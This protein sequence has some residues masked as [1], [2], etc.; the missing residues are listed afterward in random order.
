MSAA[1]AF[2]ISKTRISDQVYGYLRGEILSGRLAPGDR[3]NL[4]ALVERLKISKMPVK[5][6]IGRL[7]AEGLLE[8]LPQ[9]GTFVS[10]VD[11]R[12]LAET[13]A[14]RI[15]LEVL[16]GKLAVA[17]VSKAELTRLRE[18]IAEMETSSSK[19]EAML[20]ID[21]NFAF[22]E[23]IINLSD[24]RRLIEFY[25]QLRTPIQMAGVHFGA[26]DWYERV[27]QDQKEHRHIVRALEQ[28]NAAA[29]EKAITAHLERAQIAM[30]AHVER[31]TLSGAVPRAQASSNGIHKS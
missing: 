8:V 19:R 16:A 17:Q 21:K 6:A 20:Y 4:E 15:A 13:Y 25:R 29:V 7:A 26:E 10:R 30:V 24:N 2:V 1:E 12:D 11:A 31:S 5:E 3:I 22:H 27:G 14:L 28:R 18:L 23:L 9:R